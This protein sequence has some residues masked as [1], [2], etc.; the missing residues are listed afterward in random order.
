MSISSA[1]RWRGGA[2]G[3]G[4]VPQRSSV[5]WDFPTTVLDVVTMGLYGRLGLPRR[6]GRAERTHDM[7]ALEDIGIADYAA[8]QIGQLSGGQQQRVFIAR[9]LVRDADLCFLGEPMAGVDATTEAMI[10]ALLQRLRDRGKTVVVVHH[11]LSTVKRWFDWLAMLN[12]RV[13]AQGPVATTYTAAN[14]RATCGGQLAVLDPQTRGL[15]KRPRKAGKADARR[16]SF[17]TDHAGPGADRAVGTALLGAQVGAL[18]CF[19]VLR[20][21][22]L[23]GDVPRCPGS[24]RAICWPEDAACPSSWGAALVAGLLAAGSVQVILRLT[25][26]KPDAA[27]GVVLSSFFALGTVLLSLIQHRGGA[28]GETGWPSPPATWSAIFWPIRTA[29]NAAWKTPSPRWRTTCTGRARR[30]R[31]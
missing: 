25:R 18:G 7:A 22:S 19:S 11:D 31:G 16:A 4:Y 30:W 5:D 29:R 27:M 14:L 3:V 17:R 10:V 26:I 2:G 12:R 8:R 9:A 20:R 15:T 23:M 13:I 1:S 24:A 28:A 21:Q 6:P